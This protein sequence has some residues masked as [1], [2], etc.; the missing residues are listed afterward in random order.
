VCMNDEYKHL[1]KT[2]A[3]AL[4]TD[5]RWYYTG[6]PCKYG[7]YAP[8][9]APRSHCKEC[10]RIKNRAGA[11]EY[12]KTQAWKDYQREY[13]KQYR[14]DPANKERL[15]EIRIRYYVKKHYNGDWDAYNNRKVR[16]NAKKKD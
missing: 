5:S 12:H 2:R 7:H 16:K 14:N 1:P 15:D 11:R 13:Q 8:R 6:K 9:Q 3:E 4:E 10:L